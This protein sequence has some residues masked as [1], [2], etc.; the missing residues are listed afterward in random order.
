MSARIHPR[1]K[2]RRRLAAAVW[3]AGESV[4]GLAQSVLPAPYYSN[5]T[6]LRSMATMT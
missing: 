5:R 6:S 2:R 3:N 4:G 1:T